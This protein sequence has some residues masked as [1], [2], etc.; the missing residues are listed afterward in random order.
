MLRKTK[1]NLPTAI[2]IGSSSLKLLQLSKLRSS[3]KIAKADYV[4]L[5]RDKDNSSLI[6]KDSLEKLVK[7]NQ[8]TGAVVTSIPLDRINACTYILPNMPVDEIEPALI[9]KIKQNLEAGVK[10]D[11]ISFDYVCSSPQNNGNKDIYAL[12]FKI[13]KKTILD[14]VKLFKSLSL[15]LIS[16]EPKAYAIIEALSLFKNISEQETALAL[17]L[18]ANSSSIIIVTSGLPSLIMPLAATGNGF[19]EALSGCY[20]LDWAKA[21]ALKIK[22]GLG[23]CP[24]LS[25]Q[26]ENLVIDIEHTF[27]YFTQQLVKS[28]APQIDRLILCGGSAALKNLDKFLTDKLNVPVNVFNPVDFFVSQSEYKVSQLVRDNSCAFAGVLG[29]AAKFI[30]GGLGLEIKTN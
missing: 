27:K 5:K 30:D 13:D 9:W 24:G 16:V 17:Q 4:S 8:V 26:L 18:G 28:K 19:T 23:E 2:E 29:L 6:P 20:Q 10:F 11:D 21:E 15:D 7:D 3:F 22:E 12:V 25:S 1:E 14:T